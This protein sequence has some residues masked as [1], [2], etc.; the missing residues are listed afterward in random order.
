MEM[1]YES[2]SELSMSEVLDAFMKAFDGYAVNFSRTEISSMLERRGFCRELSFGALHDGELV[3]FLL[4]GIGCYDGLM[5]CYDCGTGTLPAYRG[6]GLAGRLFRM[7]L[8]VLKGAGVRQYLLEVLQSNVAAISLY[9]DA[10]FDVVADYECFRQDIDKLR[11][12][13]DGAY[14][15]DMREVEAKSLVDLRGFCDFSPS[16]QNDFDSIVRGASGLIIRA[17][18]IDGSPVGYCAFDP[19]TGDIAQIAVDRRCRR[20]GIASALLREVVAFSKTDKVKVLNI[21]SRCESMT[22]FLD[23]V[24]LEKGLSQFGMRRTI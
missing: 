7:S 3:A 19:M 6:Q 18:F 24:N 17:A 22:G 13:G 11:L 1:E 2:L 8:P 12:G 10:G 4:N 5:T 16:W 20:Q 23:A 14:C 9:K 21:D 15:P